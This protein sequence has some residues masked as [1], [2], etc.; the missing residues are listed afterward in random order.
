MSSID[1]MR[2]PSCGAT[3]SIDVWLSE[4]T[5]REYLNELLALKEHASAINDYVMLFRPLKTKMPTAKA[6]RI[7]RE[8]LA[9]CEDVG[10]LALACEKAVEQKRVQWNNGEP[11]RVFDNHNYLKPILASTSSVTVVREEK[12]LAMVIQPQKTS[13]QSQGLAALEKL[14]R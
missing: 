8:T 9:L 12:S 3:F 14:K 4:K 1:E 2:C 10:R 6:L 7:L 11:R 13:K 5:G